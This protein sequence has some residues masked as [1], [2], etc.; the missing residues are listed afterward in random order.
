MKKFLIGV[1][2][3][4][5][6][7]VVF[8]L[9]TAG[10]LIAL[11]VKVNPT[12]LVLKT[13]DNE[14]IAHNARFEIDTLGEE[15]ILVVEVYPSIAADKS[16]V[17]ESDPSLGGKVRLERI[18]ETNRYRVIPE[19]TGVARLTVRAAANIN[20]YQS[21]TFFIASE[22]I[23]RIEL[24]DGNGTVIGGEY[25]LNS[26]SRIFYDIQPIDALAGNAVRWESTDPDVFTVTQ[27]GTLYP[28]SRGIAT[29]KL[30][31]TDR[32]GKNHL[33][34]IQIDTS[35]AVVRSLILGFMPN[36]SH[37]PNVTNAAITR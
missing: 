21:I 35:A 27:N 5:P 34:R 30:T 37:S 23:E 17:W 13:V 1:I 19:K 9:N 28:V 8:A 16:V 33:K 12:Q 11:S 22:I 14:E 18:G 20:L 4:I 29:L 24:Y 32:T 6:I 25:A 31:A 7:I 3:I 26:A 15:M 2:L 36:T 10:S